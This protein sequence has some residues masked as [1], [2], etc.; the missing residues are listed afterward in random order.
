MA[1]SLLPLAFHATGWAAFGL[2][3]AGAIID[4]MLISALTPTT[5][6]ESGRM[7]DI[8]L[9]TATLGAKI[10]K[11]YGTTRV[12][13][14]II[15]GTKYTEHVH[16]SSSG[17][18]GGSPKQESKSYTYSAS[19][20]ILISEGPIKSIKKVFAD[21]NDFDMSSVDYNLYYGDQSQEPDDFMQSIEGTGKVP[22]YR[23]LAYIVFKN[24]NVTDF[25]N[26]IPSFSFVVEYPKNNLKDIVTDICLAAGLT[27]TLDFNATSLANIT[28]DGFSRSGGDA[29]KDQIDSLRMCHVFDAAERR[30]VVEFLIRDFSN[31]IAL[32][33]NDYGAYET[34]PED[35]PISITDAHDI[36]LPRMLT[37]NYISSDNDYQ[38]GS[39]PAK[40]QLTNAIDEK[41]VSTAVVLTDA[42]AKEVAELRLAE[43]WLA[44]TTFDFKT[45]SKFGWVLP[46]DIL[47]VELPDGTRQLMI[48]N[49]TNYGRPGINVIKAT[50]VYSGVYQ[51]ATRNV[52]AQPEPIVSVPTEIFYALLDIPKLP[53]DTSD[54]NDYIY[55]VSGASNYL[56]CNVYRSSDSGASYDLAL[57]NSRNGIVGTAKTV[58]GNSRPYSWDNANTLD[59]YIPYGTLASHTKLEVLNYYNVA[60]VGK[61]IIQYRYAELIGENIYRLSGLLRGRFGTEMYTGTHE[62]GETF[63]VIDINTINALPV[64]K[65]DWYKDIAL[66]IGPRPLSILNAKYKNTTLNAQGI[67]YKPWAGCHLKADR[68]DGTWTVSWIRRTRKDG[69]WKDYADVP[70]NESSETYQVDILDTAGTV[71]NTF[72]TSTPK[73]TYSGSCAG[74]NIYQVSD[75][76]GRGWPLEWRQ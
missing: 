40:R 39:Q 49:S 52:D 6:T 30:G 18:K 19:F 66:K 21:G 50:R 43:T 7:T 44:R 29:Y 10:I 58:L 31:V 62:S 3:I 75:V 55:F 15:W 2:S 37:L 20:A 45:G 11:G 32:S 67:M 76:R 33:K 59:V 71:I 72:A 73:F 12:T 4:N 34:D 24:F 63:V 64:A 23:G 56:G 41:S 27:E 74:A 47:E 36:S 61:E 68:K 14:N 8:D 22:A 26:R 42:A 38:T 25:G 5:V 48:V 28:V 54:T 9:Q 65:D 46:C 1:A 57:Q 60:A 35:E 13:G 69:A 70:L 53:P 17:G 16:T 51:I